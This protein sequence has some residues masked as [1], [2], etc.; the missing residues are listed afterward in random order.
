[1]YAVNGYPKNEHPD[2]DDEDDY[3]HAA[4]ATASTVFFLVM[5][6]DDR[7][8]HNRPHFYLLSHVIVTGHLETQPEGSL[9]MAGWKRVSVLPTPG[10]PHL[11]SWLILYLVMYRSL[12]YR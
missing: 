5:N 2:E 3:G 4:E 10:V 1:M 7:A 9:E 11:D 8:L 6:F 12:L